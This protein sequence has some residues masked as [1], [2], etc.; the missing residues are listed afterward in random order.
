MSELTLW[1][2]AGT[3]RVGHGIRAR[4]DPGV[5]V[6]R[7]ERALNA[8]REIG[9]SLAFA[10]FTFDPDEPGSVVIVPEQTETLDDLKLAT[11]PLP[12]ATAIETG[13]EEWRDGFARAVDKLAG[14]GL[15]K[16][17]LARQVKVHYDGPISPSAIANRLRPY[18]GD[19]LF[20]VDGLVGVTPE[21]LV[22]LDTGMMRSLALA[23]TAPDEDRLSDSRVELEHS[24]TASAVKSSLLSHLT[25]EPNV[26]RSIVD[27]GPIKHWG[28]FLEGE[29]LPGTTVLSLVGALHPTPA[30]AGV[31]T[32]AALA[33]IREIER[34]HRG[35]YAGPI[36]WFDQNGDGEFAIALRCGLVDEDRLT[37]YA[38][39]G[40]VPGADSEYELAETDLK[41]GPML[42]ALSLQL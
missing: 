39:G 25:G 14:P 30:V 38:G 10:S 3:T 41:L 4:I 34:R 31:P 19:Y 5:G 16:V 37:L 24:L 36:G 1:S 2:H 6:S 18:P 40:L 8:I 15:E 35:R 22:S 32:D 12:K 11:V 7:Y 42:E 28:T 27:L 33:L 26:N 17:V 13:I 9:A 29:A 20:A 23:G 21:L